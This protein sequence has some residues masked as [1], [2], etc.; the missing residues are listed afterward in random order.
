MKDD[1]F[2][3]ERS[4]YH[5]TFIHCATAGATHQQWRSRLVAFVQLLGQAPAFH[6]TDKGY[7]RFAEVLVTEGIGCI[8]RGHP[9]S[10]LS[11]IPGE[12]ILM[13]PELPRS[14]V[15]PLCKALKDCWQG[16]PEQDA[17]T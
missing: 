12:I 15:E 13:H 8:F 16:I 4:S 5:D 14:L 11:D 1:D 10:V 6:I 3:W 9:F 2:Q 17:L 7:Q